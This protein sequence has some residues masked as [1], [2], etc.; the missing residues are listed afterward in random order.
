MFVTGKMI[1]VETI[2]GMGE[3][4]KE[5]EGESEFDY[6]NCKKIC[7]CHNVPC[8]KNNMIIKIP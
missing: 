6:D 5:N 4:I 3:E 8:V 2:P 1:H 7:K